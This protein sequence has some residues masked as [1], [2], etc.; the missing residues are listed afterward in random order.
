MRTLGADCADGKKKNS[1]IFWLLCPQQES[2]FSLSESKRDLS[3]KKKAMLLFDNQC[4]RGFTPASYDVHRRGAQ[5][6]RTSQLRPL[7]RGD[8]GQKCFL[9]SR[10]ISQYVLL[11][12]LILYSWFCIHKHTRSFSYIY[13]FHSTKTLFS[14]CLFLVRYLYPVIL[15]YVPSITNKVFRI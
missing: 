10:F 6:E 9:L 3:V 15:I 7:W 12:F 8:G 11:D 5:T 14:F 2:I 13:V 4:W 1:K